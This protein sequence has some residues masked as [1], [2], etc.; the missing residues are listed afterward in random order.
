MH[1]HELKPGQPKKRAGC[2]IFLEWESGVIKVPMSYRR[3]QTCDLVRRIEVAG[4]SAS[5]T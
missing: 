5:L 1:P 2:R 4:G 3:D